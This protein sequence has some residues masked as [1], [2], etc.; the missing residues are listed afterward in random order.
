LVCGEVSGEGGQRSSVG[1]AQVASGGGEVDNGVQLVEAHMQAWSASSISS[2]S[3]GGE[4][5]E[6]LLHVGGFG[7]GQTLRFAVD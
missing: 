7:H 3:E 5:L 4:R 6:M 2:S 1:D